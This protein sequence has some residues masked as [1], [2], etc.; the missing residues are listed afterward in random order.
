MQVLLEA[1]LEDQFRNISGIHTIVNIWD[2]ILSFPHWLGT[3]QCYT[4][5]QLCLQSDFLFK[6]D[7]IKIKFQLCGDVRVIDEYDM[8]ERNMFWSI[9]IYITRD[10]FEKMPY[11]ENIP[12]V[13]SITFKNN[14]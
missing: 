9:F 7:N 3:L 11:F 8:G 5:D 1:N 13:I 2:D 6:E 12:A 4:G 10:S 14:I